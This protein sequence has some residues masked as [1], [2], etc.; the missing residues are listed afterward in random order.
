MASTFHLHELTLN[1]SHRL[2]ALLP[3]M[4]E[5]S[6]AARRNHRLLVADIAETP[7]LVENK[8][9]CIVVSKT[10]HKWWHMSG[11]TAA[12]CMGCCIVAYKAPHKLNMLVLMPWEHCKW[13]L[14]S[15]PQREVELVVVACC[16]EG[17]MTLHIE[18]DMTAG[19]M[20]MYNWPGT[21]LRK[22]QH[23]HHKEETRPQPQREHRTYL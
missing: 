14:A 12:W 23:S 9:Q 20:L 22:G 17:R 6:L 19:M 7:E 5:A 21:G 18:Q 8:L 4:E 15:Q 16:I 13:V 2:W 1:G 11:R 10:V 3:A